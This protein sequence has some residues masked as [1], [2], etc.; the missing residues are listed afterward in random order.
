[1]TI[2]RKV[3]KEGLTP[4]LDALLSGGWGVYYVIGSR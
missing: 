1:M 2:K 4:L 3:K